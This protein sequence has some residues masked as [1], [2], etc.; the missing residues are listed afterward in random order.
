M[1]SLRKCARLVRDAAADGVGWFALWK[2]GRSWNVWTFWPEDYCYNQGYMELLP[3]D[4]ERLREIVAADADAV[5]LN[6]YYNN[7]ACSE[8]GGLPDLREFVDALRWQYEDC[9]PCVSD[10]DVVEIK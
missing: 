4:A 8:D 6:G 2:E 3:E 7:I 1:A 9:H 5:L 10:W